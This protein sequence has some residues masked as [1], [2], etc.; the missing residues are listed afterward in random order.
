MKICIHDERGNVTEVTDCR[1]A[2]IETDEG[3][4]VDINDNLSGQGLAVSMRYGRML[5]IPRSA[6][7]VGIY[8]EP[9]DGY[10]D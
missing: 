3:G 6:N 1:W 4:L 5:I 7:T 8:P 10:R 2:V 9:K